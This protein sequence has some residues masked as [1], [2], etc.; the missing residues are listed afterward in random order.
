M[1][2]VC[3]F[4]FE[5]FLT[6]QGIYNDISL[7]FRRRANINNNSSLVYFSSHV[8]FGEGRLGIIVI[9]PVAVAV[10]AEAVVVVVVV[11]VVIVEM[12]VLVALFK[13]RVA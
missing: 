1:F 10:V 8:K 4:L 6:F 11:A 5:H 2:L 7:Q 3:L 13:E 9:V 12:V